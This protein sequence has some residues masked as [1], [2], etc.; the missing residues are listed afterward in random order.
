[1]PVPTAWIAEKAGN[2]Q[3][4][5]AQITASSSMREIFTHNA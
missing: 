5:T 2:R 1:M 3:K 4:P